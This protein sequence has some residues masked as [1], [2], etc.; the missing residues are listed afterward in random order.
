M[1]KTGTRK[2]SGQVDSKNNTHRVTF[3]CNQ[4]MHMLPNYIVK[5]KAKSGA[6]ITVVT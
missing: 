6:K 2:P 5:S 3:F 1:S 4:L